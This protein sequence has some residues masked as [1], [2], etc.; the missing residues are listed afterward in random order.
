M[1][2]D[3]TTSAAGELAAVAFAGRRGVRTFGEPTLGTPNL[4][5]YTNLADGTGLTAAG[6]YAYDRLGRV[7]RGPIGP[8]VPVAT[9]WTQ[10]GTN[11]DPV[12][13]AAAAWLHRQPACTR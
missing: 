7:Y 1:L 5:Q 3:R 13:Q 4:V 10:L 8:D 12:L 2:L 9:D 11:K 6:V